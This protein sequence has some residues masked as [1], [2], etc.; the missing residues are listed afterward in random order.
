[1]LNF[2][3]LFWKFWLCFALWSLLHADLLKICNR[4]LCLWNLWRNYGKQRQVRPKEHHALFIFNGVSERFLFLSTL[5]PDLPTSWFSF[6]FSFVCLAF[7]WYRCPMFNQGI[8]HDGL[9]QKYLL[10]STK[11]FAI[12]HDIN[13][14]SF[15]FRFNFSAF[16]PLNSDS[17]FLRLRILFSL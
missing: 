8:I 9:C 17:H 15:R 1:M 11:A 10:H 7:D 6:A 4:L 5:P 14:N 2:D 12:F 3:G 16:L 13:W